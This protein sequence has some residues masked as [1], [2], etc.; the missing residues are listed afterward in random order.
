MFSAETTARLQALRAIK[1]ERPLTTE[2]QKEALRLIRSDRTSAAYASK[3]SK[4][5]TASVDG[6]VVLKGFLDAFTKKG[7][8]N[9][10]V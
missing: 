4:E 1:Q 3:A 10:G 7:A 5:K 8:D 9:A 2:E 6:N